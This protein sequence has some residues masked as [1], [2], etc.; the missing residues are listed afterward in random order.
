MKVLRTVTCISGFP[1][2]LNEG[3]LMAKGLFNLT[4]GHI[5]S[6]WFDIETKDELM[7]L[8]DDE[9]IKRANELLNL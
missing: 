9:F 5:V 6:M 4:Y 2:E 3:S 7:E 8:S 1:I